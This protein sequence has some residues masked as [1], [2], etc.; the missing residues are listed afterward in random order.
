MAKYNTIDS[1]IWED[2]LDFSS[3]Q[4]LVYVYLF[5]NASCR[6]S[7]LYKIN[8]KTIELHTGV[9][10]IEFK[11]IIGKLV[12]YDYQTQELWVRGKMKRILIGFAANT[13]MRKSVE[14]DYKG[15]KSPLIKEAFYRKYEEALKGLV[16]PPLPLP[17]ALPLKQEGGAGEEFRHSPLE[18]D[19][20]QL[21]RFEE[22][23]TDYPLKIERS[24]ALR[25]FCSEILTLATFKRLMIAVG[26]YK[27][28]LEIYDWKAA[29]TA[30]RFLECW[31]DWV[32]YIETGKPLEHK[33]AA[34]SNLTPPAPDY[35]RLDKEFWE[36]HNEAVRQFEEDQKNPN[37]VAPRFQ[38]P[39][40]RAHA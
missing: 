17:L 14:A 29:K 8:V 37:F 7:G 20:D 30:A 6:P 19:F 11:S 33:P 32:D 15:L 36:R 35:S 31:Q 10:E 25:A 3:L 22:F 23:L 18:K 26:K 13:K 27:K 9:P 16:S 4:K 24:Y 34:H 39:N 1:E 40:G 2:L 38:V 21:A 5:S 12:E 28:H